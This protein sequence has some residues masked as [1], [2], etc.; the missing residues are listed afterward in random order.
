MCKS[1][2]PQLPIQQFYDHFQFLM[3]YNKETTSKHSLSRGLALCCID[4]FLNSFFTFYQI[5][6][7]SREYTQ[8]KKLFLSKFEK[9]IRRETEIF[10]QFQFRPQNVL[11]NNFATFGQNN[12]SKYISSRSLRIRNIFSKIRRYSG[13]PATLK[14]RKIKHFL[15]AFLLFF[16]SFLAFH[17]QAQ[18]RFC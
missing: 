13:E 15:L 1:S 10:K 17:T 6:T 9:K 14:F 2:A 5:S 3:K 12:I 11:V 16:F 4:E 8:E 18:P 7:R